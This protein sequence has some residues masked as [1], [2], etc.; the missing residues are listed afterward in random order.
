MHEIQKDRKIINNAISAY[1]M[2]FVSGFFLL[3]KDNPYLNN[4]FVKGHT[5]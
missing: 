4:D 5:R 2:I 1:F 3:N